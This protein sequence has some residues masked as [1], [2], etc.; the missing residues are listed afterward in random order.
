[1]TDQL[2]ISGDDDHWSMFSRTPA[3][4]GRPPTHSGDD[5]DE[6]LAA[7]GFTPAEID[8]LRAADAIA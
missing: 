8:E 5:D 1:M 3:T 4:V 7:W 6:A 2:S